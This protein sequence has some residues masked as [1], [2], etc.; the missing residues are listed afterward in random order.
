MVQGNHMERI[1]PSVCEVYPPY[2]E[3]MLLFHCHCLNIACRILHAGLSGI[4]SSVF[5]R[6][7]LISYNRSNFGIQSFDAF[8]E[9]LRLLVCV[10]TY[11]FLLR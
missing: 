3:L 1:S 8:V 4:K 5:L 6:Y 10:S 2:A 11:S 7:S 9:Q